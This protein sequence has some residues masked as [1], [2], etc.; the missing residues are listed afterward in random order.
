MRVQMLTERRSGRNGAFHRRNSSRCELA[1]RALLRYATKASPTS[2]QR[3]R[4][5]CAHGRNRLP[6]AD[7]LQFGG[8]ASNEI[9]DGVRAELLPFD[10]SMTKTLI[11]EST[12]VEEIITTTSRSTA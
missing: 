11:Q 4:L 12:S 2:W 9:N 3:G 10:L 5:R 7:R 8:F 6:T 1:G